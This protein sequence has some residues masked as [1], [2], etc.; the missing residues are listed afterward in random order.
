ML[1]TANPVKERLN[2]DYK[3]PRELVAGDNVK[4][5]DIGRD[6]TVS[7][8]SEK[9][10][11]ALIASG[12]M[13][14]WVGF[15]NLMIKEV[16]THKPSRTIK[17]PSKIDRVATTEIDIRG[18][19]SDEA[20]IELGRFIDNAVVTG[21][22]TVTIIHGKGTGVLRTAVHKYLRTNKFIKNFRVGLFGE[23]ENGVTIAELK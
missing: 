4:I 5:I 6:G 13:K 15:N 3:L 21:I 8:I 23:G 10:K 1:D 11:K 16:K 19:A 20:I 14:I 7:E 9:N 2:S 18:F 22:N 12:N 17:T